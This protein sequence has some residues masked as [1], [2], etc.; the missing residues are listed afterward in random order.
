MKSD[1]LTPVWAIGQKIFCKTK[2]NYLL[3][4]K[5]LCPGQVVASP[6]SLKEVWSGVLTPV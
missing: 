4:C 5:V 3:N 1:I 6:E 2:E